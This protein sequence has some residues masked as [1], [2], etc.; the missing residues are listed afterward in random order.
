MLQLFELAAVQ[1]G[2]VDF[3]LRVARTRRFSNLGAVG[4]V[5]RGQPNVRKAVA[6]LADNIWAQAEEL[7]F[8]LDDTGGIPTLSA[9]IVHAPGTSTRQSIEIALAV[10]V[11]L[12]RRFL[13]PKWTPEMVVFRHRKPANVAL[14]IVT[15]GAVPLF[16]QDLDGIV[17][18]SADLDIEIPDA[19]PA[20]AI[21]L[22]RNLEF[23]AG[24]RTTDFVEKA[25]HLIA[26]ML[27]GGN[28]QTAHIAHQLGMDRWTL[29][30]RPERK[31]TSFSALLKR[32]RAEVAQAYIDAG[33]RSLTEI[34]GLVGF[35]F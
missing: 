24:R 21:Q 19:D 4:L 5:M 30:R 16:G 28:C 33:D 35:S 31:G 32:E 25:Q 3:G 26:L 14:Y 22:A 15:F 7:L 18:R 27:S 2:V 34:A 9:T 10:T 29:H 6:V 17:L 13:G 20:A 12:L 23:V 8:D 1:A 11:G